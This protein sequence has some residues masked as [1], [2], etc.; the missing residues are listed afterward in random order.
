MQI[1]I[2]SDIHS[3]FWGSKDTFNFIKPS[4]KILALLGD[5]GVCGTTQDWKTY[6]RF[7]KEVSNKFELVLIITGNHEYYTNNT[8]KKTMAVIDHQL[9]EYF[10]KIP[11]VK[12]LNNKSLDIDIN[13]KKYKIIGS[14][15]WSY[16]PEID[17]KDIQ[18]Y[19]N[20]YSNIYI[21]T[22]STIK[23]LLPMH[24]SAMFQ[25][26]Y[27]FIKKKIKQAKK[28]NRK[29]IIF[30]HHKPYIEAGYTIKTTDRPYMSDCSGLFNDSIILWAYGHTHIKDD[31]IIN[32]IRFYS[33]CKGYPNQRTGYNKSEVVTID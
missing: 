21:N 26:N 14:T 5:I 16:I 6:D 11:N 25:H 10:K 30:T 27:D 17:Q 8:D 7:I 1:Q 32:G 9:K 20:D 23:R 4:A 31:R 22:E 33:N 12:L 18:N 3:E 24:T 13:D 19:M 15:L 28:E 29:V 2:V